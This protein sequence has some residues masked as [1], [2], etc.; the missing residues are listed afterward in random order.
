MPA[1]RPLPGAR[2]GFLYLSRCVGAG[3]S[4]RVE[5]FFETGALVEY[6]D[7][8]FWENAIEFLDIPT[9]LDRLHRWSEVG[10]S[11]QPPVSTFE[12]AEALKARFDSLKG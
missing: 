2:C 3:A 6:R 9:Y 10:A 8:F 5:S 7:A 4:Q 1:C 12:Y 11:H